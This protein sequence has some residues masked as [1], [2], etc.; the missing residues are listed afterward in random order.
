VG[1]RLNFVGAVTLS[2]SFHN[3]SS[4]TFSLVVPLGKRTIA[5]ATSTI[6][7]DGSQLTSVE[8]D[9]LPPIGTGYGY[10][11]RSDIGDQSNN[12]RVDADFT[13]QTNEGSIE[14]EGSE[15]NSQF[16]TRITETGGLVVLGGH[17]A[18]SPWLNNSFA[19]IETHDLSSVKV[20]AN[21]QY[22]TSTGWRGLAVLPVL[23]P[24]VRNTIRLDDQN[25]PIELGFDLQDKTIVP[26]SRTGVLVK[27]KGVRVN[28]ALFQL[29]TEKGEPVPNGAEVTVGEFGTIYNAALRG[30]VFIPNVSFPA[31]LHVHWADQRCDA[32]VENT[33]SREPLP[34]VGPVTCKEVR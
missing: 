24:Y 22:I 6:V 34:H 13:Y 23:A 4:A 26:R 21:N 1:K 12:R 31:H 30:E 19:L 17:V 20:F 33:N 10:R 32:T 14:L 8:Y 18:P 9:R 15:I 27:F 3:A 2:N 25:I 5:S 11:L 16:N 28:G 29:V 7:R